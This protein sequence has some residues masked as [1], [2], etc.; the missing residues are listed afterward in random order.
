M[1]E[2]IE[3]VIFSEEEI[4]RNV[5]RLGE[6]ISR[7]YAGKKLL[8]VSILKGSIV[9]MA[10]LM[11][12]ITIP[13]S[14]DFMAVSSYGSGT[15]TS[16]VVRIIKDLDR[17]ISGWNVLI[18][19]DILDSGMTLQ[20]IMELLSARDPESIRICTLF[21]KPERRVT[22][23]KAD[24]IGLQVPDEFIVGYGLDYDEIY[25][26]VPYIGV[27]KPEIYQKAD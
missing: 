15:K 13:C 3:R 18:V 1:F 9:F 16:G 6:Q 20:Y 7:D 14:I 21:D 24:Y 26:N 11:R 17:P 2:D 5:K 4:S 23:V 22:N 25:R 19:E 27:L 12:A 8:L 10:D